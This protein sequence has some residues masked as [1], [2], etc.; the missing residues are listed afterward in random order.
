MR[1]T[2]LYE[3]CENNNQPLDFK[4]TVEILKSRLINKYV[5][6]I[7]FIF[8]SKPAL[9]KPKRSPPA[10]AVAPPPPFSMPVTFKYA[11]CYFRL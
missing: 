9:E 7:Q 1:M 10:T 11:Q 3:N 5:N 8:H 6:C 4:Y 2:I